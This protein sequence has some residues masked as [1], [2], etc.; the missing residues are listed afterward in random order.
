MSESRHEN[1]PIFVIA[2][3]TIVVSVPTLATRI[4]HANY[5]VQGLSLIA[6]SLLQAL[7]PPRRRALVQMLAISGL[8]TLITLIWQGPH[9]H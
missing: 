5:V 8:F 6:A 3:L 7:F 2:K 4:L 9:L 1:D